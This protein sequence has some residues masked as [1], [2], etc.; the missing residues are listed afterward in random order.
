MPAVH[1]FLRSGDW[2]HL[3]CCEIYPVVFPMDKSSGIMGKAC[4]IFINTNGFWLAAW[5][6]QW[7]LCGQHYI[8]M[9]FGFVSPFD[10]FLFLFLW[11]KLFCHVLCTLAY[12][13]FPF[14]SSRMWKRAGFPSPRP[15]PC[16]HKLLSAFLMLFMMP[17]RCAYWW[18]KM[19]S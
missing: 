19:I 9:F 7:M 11:M 2:I 16:L 3:D 14:L 18:V 1:S 6:A 12:R 4:V 15:S 10:W 13:C 17:M 8:N 5:E